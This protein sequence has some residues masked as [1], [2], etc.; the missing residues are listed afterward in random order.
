VD[1]PAWGLFSP[2]V[3][4]VSTPGSALIV[5]VVGRS[6]L[7]NQQGATVTLVDSTN[8]YPNITRVV[9]GKALYDLHFGECVCVC[10]ACGLRF[11]FW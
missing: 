3:S 5:R 7:R 6:G 10:S 9:G 2:R 11:L 8:T 1:L 4:N